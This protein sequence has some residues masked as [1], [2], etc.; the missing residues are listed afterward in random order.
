M[1]RD[2]DRSVRKAAVNGLGVFSAQFSKELLKSISDAL[3][4]ALKDENSWSVRKAAA[5][6]F[7][8]FSARLSEWL[9]KPV[10]EGLLVALKDE[11][12][13]VTHSAVNALV[14]L[15]AHLSFED[16]QFAINLLLNA[17]NEESFNESIHGVIEIL[18]YLM[19]NEYF[20]IAFGKRISDALSSVQFISD[21]VSSS[22]LETKENYPTLADGNCAMNA[23][24]LGVCELVLYNKQQ[25]NNGVRKIAEFLNPS[26][27][28]KTGL[29]LLEWL[30]K[31]TDNDKRQAILAP[32]LREIAVDYIKSHV[33]YYKESY[34]AGLSAAFEQYKLNQP[35]DT[36]SVHS[37]IRKKFDELNTL[38]NAQK[39]N[40]DIK[41]IKEGTETKALLT[42]WNEGTGKNSSGFREYLDNLRQPA[43][44]SGDRER[45]G[46]EVEIGA[47]AFILGITIKNVKP[48][49]GQ[50]QLLGIGYGYVPG[51]SESEIDHLVNLNIGS[52][53]HYNFR[54][55]VADAQE[56]KEKLQLEMLTERQG[57]YLKDKNRR[58]TIL[59]F[60]NNNRDCVVSEPK[61]MQELCDK[62]ERI[63]LFVKDKN[64]SLR[65]VNDN[66]LKSRITPVSEALKKKVIAAHIKPLCFTIQHIS[67]H[68]SYINNQK[69]ESENI[70]P[71]TKASP[72]NP[73]YSNMVPTF[74][75]SLYSSFDSKI[76]YEKDERKAWDE[77][78]S[79]DS[80]DEK[81]AR[82]SVVRTTT[83][84][85]SGHSSA[86]AS[87]STSAAITPFVFSGA[88]SNDN[89]TKPE[90]AQD[91]KESKL[92][93]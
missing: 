31:E 20:N 44:G 8:V 4:V 45:W 90:I 77:K 67:G 54:I 80:R 88:N 29:T 28:E 83:G 65:F 16:L 72:I 18:A 69:T 2:D 84:I 66:L 40:S 55:E 58:E 74:N 92:S 19:S 75:R 56:L 39:Q 87:I 15:S 21:A 41:D 70:L 50:Q 52:R 43:R 48:G 89:K 73:S 85:S 53:F 78:N 71:A 63:G 1:L 59:A 3:L 37:H 24:V 51:L 76:N 46:S 23:V 5:D 61:E 49:V 14:S 34:E 27:L 86:S 30:E 42:W 17:V 47:L 10:V 12:Q 36:F 22:S 81:E 93:Q 38:I 64:Q 79:K 35:D 9:I 91:K 62:L 13:S 33:D 57:E 6:T 11:E 26:L 25:L 68:W 7:G 60:I 82:P 32:I